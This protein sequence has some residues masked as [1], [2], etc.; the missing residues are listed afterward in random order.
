M[1][2][3]GKVEDG[4]SFFEFKLDIKDSIL[5]TIDSEIDSKVVEG[6]KK[7][8]EQEISK[9]KV[10]TFNS[11]IDSLSFSSLFNYDNILLLLLL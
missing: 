1:G 10:I 3:T 2:G 4:H 8:M 9:Q 5:D 11:M 7:L 6:D